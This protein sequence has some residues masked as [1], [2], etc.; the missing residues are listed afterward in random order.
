MREPGAALAALLS[1]VAALA[2]DPTGLWKWSYPN[3]DGRPGE[4]ILRLTFSA[5]IAS[6]PQDGA[7][8]SQLLRRADTRLRHA[9]QEGRNRVL[10][11]DP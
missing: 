10:A 1:S 2:G 5:G 4:Y 6:W 9:K 3:R 8:L 11:R 7:D